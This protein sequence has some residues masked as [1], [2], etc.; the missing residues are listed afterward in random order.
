MFSSSEL[1]VWFKRSWLLTKKQLCL[2]RR[3]MNFCRSR[4]IE[5]SVGVRDERQTKV[6]ILAASYVLVVQRI[7]R[8]FPKL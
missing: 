2:G 5:V 1:L 3:V 7:E 6:R 8:E 4:S